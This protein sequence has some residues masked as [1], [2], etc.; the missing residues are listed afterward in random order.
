MLS[1][2]LKKI[3][4]MAL[5][6]T[7]LG[8]LAA[9]GPKGPVLKD[10]QVLLKISA[11]N[12]GYG[13][14]WLDALKAEYMKNNPNV[15]IDYNYTTVQRKDQLT[16]LKSGAADADLYITGFNLHGQLY[17]GIKLVDLSDVYT[18]IGEKIIPSVK[19]QLEH[20]GVQYA[21]PWAT[22]TLGMLY[23]KDFFAE[24]NIQV[25]RTTD[26]LLGAANTITQMRKNGTTNSYAFCYSAFTETGECYWDYM[27]YPWMAQYEGTTNYEKYWDCK[28]KDDTQ[29]DIG[30]TSEY[31]SVLRVLEVYEEILK[32]SNEYNHY[33]STEDSFTYAQGRFLDK[34]AQMMANGDWIVQ[35]MKKGDY[36]E[37]ETKDIA[38]MKTPILSSIVETMPMWT[39]ESNVQ[40]TVDPNNDEGLVAVSA[41]KKAA[42]EKALVA[43]IDYVDGVSTTKPTSVEGIT[44]SDGDI[45]RIQAAR[46]ITPTMAENHIMVIPE[47][48]DRIAEAKD[49]LKFVYSQKGIELYANSVYGTGLP[50]NYTKEEISNIV[51]DS[52]LLKSAYDMLGENCYLTFYSGGKN[53]VFSKGGLKPTYR[54]DAKTFIDVFAQT[55]ASLYETAYEFYEKSQTQIGTAWENLMMNKID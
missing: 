2:K 54:T 11:F 7:T 50:V 17:D 14:D 52:A 26:E 30:I 36:T 24:K 27:F 43:I 8:S 41:T 35:E 28:L 25:P 12:G 42:Y 13:L 9:C 37:E 45:E 15:V 10:G 34:E 19:A 29:Y 23:H 21:V 6:L 53:P 3:I 16:A 55:S 4:S 22:S 32:A 31:V 46:N 49:F 51:G 48:S 47:C 44:I 38:F 5:A 40:Y 1:K 20:E 18:S 39:E 33:K